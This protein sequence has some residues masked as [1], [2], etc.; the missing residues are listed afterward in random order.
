MEILSGILVA[1]IFIVSIVLILVVEGLG[2]IGGGANLFFAQN[3]GFEDFLDR[4]TL[5]VAI[6][7]IILVVLIRVVEKF[8]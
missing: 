8:S 6:S 1:L 5:V 3:K 4:V 7:F 2:S